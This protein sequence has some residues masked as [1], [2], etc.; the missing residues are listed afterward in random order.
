M[1]RAGILLGLLLASSASADPKRDSPDY[2]GRGN[3]DA[4]GGSWALWIPRIALSPLYVVNEYLIRKPL[5]KL[6]TV[7]EHDRW[8]NTITNIFEFGPDNNSF[9]VPTAL[10]DFGLLP[11]VGLYYGA[12]DTIA[13]DNAMRISAATWGPEWIAATALDRYTVKSTGTTFTVRG[14]FRREA[15]LL[16]FGIGPDVT[17][18]TQSRYGE[19]RIEGD[20]SV[21]QVLAN[22]SNI[23]LTGG[24]R[25]ISYRAGDCCGDPSLDDRIADGTLASPPG[26]NMP[27]LA[28]FQRVDLTLDT[29]QPRPSTSSGGYLQTHVETD[30]DTTNDRAWL[31]FGGTLGLAADLGNQRT[32]RIQAGVEYVDPMKGNVVPFNELA[33]LGSN[34]MPG[35]VGGWMNGPST[36]TTQIGYTWPVWL[37]LDGQTRF[38]MGNAFA[39][40]LD[41]LAMNKMRLS[42]DLGVTTVG[43]RDAGFEILFGL[44]TETLEQGGHITSVRLTFGSRKGF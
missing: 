40:H 20:V 15:D 8:I 39:G 21:R 41:G 13:K 4:D 27:Y 17:N 14:D 12:D 7:A 10:F 26:Y 31:K 1:S 30:F 11:T 16:F 6:V 43:K 22:E 32:V 2:D 18:A 37:W 33:S 9:I 3:E 5:G 36:F 34:Q 23:A 44:G 28:L 24:V 19:Q 42:G 29:R 25:S 35:F 38:S